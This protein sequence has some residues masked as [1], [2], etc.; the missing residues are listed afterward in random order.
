MAVTASTTK[1]AI[2]LKL[3]NGKTESGSTKIVSLSIGTLKT[4]A[5]AQ[6]D[7]LAKSYAIA[8]SLAACLSKIVVRI[9]YTKT[10]SIEDND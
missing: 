8:V 6:A 3:D 1:N 4:N 7:F 2:A 9:D 10:A 5:D